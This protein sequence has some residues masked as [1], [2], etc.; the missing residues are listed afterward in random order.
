MMT[1]S[2]T[3][4]GLAAEGYLAQEE[5]QPEKYEY[6]AGEVLAMVGSTREQMVV[7][8]NLYAAF[9]QPLRGGPC[10]A[11]VSDLRLRVEAAVDA[12]F[13]RDVMVFRELQDHAAVQFIEHSML[14]VEVLWKATAAFDRGDRFAA[15]RGL[16][17]LQEYV[18]VDIPS[19]RVEIFRR[20]ADPDWLFHEHRPELGDCR[21]PASGVSIPFDEIFEN[22]DPENSCLGEQP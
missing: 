3:Q 19:R 17:S 18:L 20:T 4:S 13:Y 8:G 7:A 11:Y 15:F 14:I 21:F 10:Q 16:P 6:L 1:H 5:P 22:V 2:A 9:K 12:L